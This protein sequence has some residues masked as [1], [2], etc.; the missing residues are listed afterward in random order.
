MTNSD[1]N[2]A[3]IWYGGSRDYNASPPLSNVATTMP[4]YMFP[5]PSTTQMIQ[6]QSQQI[7]IS[8]SSN[9][10]PST[11]S[12]YLTTD[13]TT[14]LKVSLPPENNSSSHGGVDIIPRIGMDDSIGDGTYTESSYGSIPQLE[15]SPRRYRTHGEDEFQYDVTATS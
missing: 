11:S 6:Q 5:C 4:S 9:N 13:E 14:Y 8:Q 7:Y 1:Q 15:A 3:S 2:N 12:G 10:P